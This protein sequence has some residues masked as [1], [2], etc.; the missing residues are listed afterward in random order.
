MDCAKARVIL[1][2]D[3]REFF[4]PRAPQRRW[5]CAGPKDPA[6]T[7]VIPDPAAAAQSWYA[8]HRV[9]P[10]N[11]MVVVTEKLASSDPEAVREI[12][13]LLMRGKQAAGL[14]KAGEIDFLP[15][16][17]AACRPALQTIIDYALQ[18]SLIPRKIDVDD[19]FDETTRVLDR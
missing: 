7:S 8:R 11:H 3:P 18:Q 2:L 19:L 13:R 6:L 4:L 17:L 16:G 1:P 9:V 5:P 15:F 14:P 10:I 12:Y